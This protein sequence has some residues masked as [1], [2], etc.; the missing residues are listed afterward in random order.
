M[1]KATIEL[2]DGR[3]INIELF[4]SDAPISVNN[5][6]KLAKEG[7]YKDLIFHRVIGNFMIQGGGMDKKLRSKSGAKPIKGEF[8]SNGVENNIKHTLGTLSMARTAVKDS[9]SSQ[10][11]IC[12]NDTPH[13]DGEYAAFGRCSDQESLR[14]VI[15]ISRVKTVSVGYY[16]DVPETPVVIKDITVTD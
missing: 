3:R 6:K 9:A 14:T 16:D 15:D 11:F 2:H 1:S 12:V 13:L 5:F 7:F 10:F 4:D 8:K